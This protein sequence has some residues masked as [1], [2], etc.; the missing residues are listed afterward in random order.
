VLKIAMV[1]DGL[2]DVVGGSFLSTAR[3]GELLRGRGHQ[4]VFIS[5]RSH[6]HACDLAERGVTIH[7][8]RGLVLPRS[9]RLCLAVPFAF[10][11][12]R[13]LREHQ[14]DIVH[15]MLPTPLGAVAGR[16]A[17]QMGLPLVMH[18]HTQPENIFMNGP[19]FPGRA[20][21]TRL[22]GRYLTWLYRQGDA[23]VHP[24]AFSQR[25][26]PVPGAS[27]QQV[28]SNG[29][30]RQRFRPLA[31]GAFRERFGLCATT[32][33]LLYVGRLHPEKDVETLIRAM[34]TILAARPGT[35]LLIVGLGYKQPTLE[36][37]VAAHDVAK[38]VTFCGF[39]S[40]ADLP[41]VYNACD[42]FVL[43]SLAELEGIAVLEAMAC[44]KPILI[45]DAKNSA[46]PDFVDGNGLVFRAHDP[47]HLAQQ[48]LQLLADATALRAMAARS[49]ANSQAFDIDE[50][51]AALESLYY[52][53]LAPA[54]P[55]CIS[56]PSPQPSFD[57]A[58]GYSSR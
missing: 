47:A 42:L 21:L 44:G 9:G 17:K 32:Q 56:S 29:V 16:V 20:A 28:I 1:C 49:R 45:A 51:A 7:R 57:I 6:R 18:S 48:A 22:F 27:R 39:V 55:E 37:L 25:Q 4:V 5:S 40:D 30:N 58:T 12:R 15:V 43:P 26:F 33:Y 36:R 13:L 52:S 41:M 8:L 34:P 23:L 54:G 10:R 50:S 19:R 24:S 3:L 14:I 53:L 31:A 38:H 35:H 2:A 11:L 46:A